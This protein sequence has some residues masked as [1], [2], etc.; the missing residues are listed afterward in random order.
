LLT[1][2]NLWH[3][4]RRQYVSPKHREMSNRLHDGTSQKT[5]FFSLKNLNA[6]LLAKLWGNSWNIQWIVILWHSPW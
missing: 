1:E 5:V 6:F 2:P 4:R 3:W